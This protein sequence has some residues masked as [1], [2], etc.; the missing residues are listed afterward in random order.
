LI[1]NSKTVIESL[2]ILIAYFLMPFY[3]KKI[4]SLKNNNSIFNGLN[5]KKKHYRMIEIYVIVSLNLK[6]ILKFVISMRT[7]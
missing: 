7:K 5:S 1:F 2:E 3:Q 4:L 6:K